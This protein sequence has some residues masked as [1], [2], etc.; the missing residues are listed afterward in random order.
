MYCNDCMYCKDEDFY[1]K[2]CNN[3]ISYIIVKIF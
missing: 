2:K 3:K 1:V